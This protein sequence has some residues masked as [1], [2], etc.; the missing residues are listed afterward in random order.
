MSKRMGYGSLLVWLCLAAGCAKLT[1]SI[2]K[3]DMRQGNF[4]D[5]SLVGQLHPG[6]SKQEVQALLG[7]PLLIDPFHPQRW[8]YVYSFYPRGN[9]TKGEERRLT[10]YFEGEILSRVEGDFTPKS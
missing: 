9:R 2:Y 5:E 4:F 10:L 6:M 3:L 7:S 8:D 1:P